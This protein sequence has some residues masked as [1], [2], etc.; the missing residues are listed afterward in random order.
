MHYDNQLGQCRNYKNY[1]FIFYKAPK[2]NN[3]WVRKEEGFIYLYIITVESLGR[4][5]VTVRC[6][7]QQNIF[8]YFKVD[9]Q[10]L[11][12]FHS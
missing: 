9:S 5:Y 4:G 2:E 7:V 10:F 3:T 6:A 11:L 12:V 1:V 8:M